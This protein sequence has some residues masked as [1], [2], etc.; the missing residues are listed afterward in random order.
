MTEVEKRMETAFASEQVLAKDW[1]TSE[2]NK[3]WKD[4]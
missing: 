1:N 4:F 3:A 2:E